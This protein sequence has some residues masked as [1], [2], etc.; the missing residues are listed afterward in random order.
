M[1]QR[2]LLRRR[3]PQGAKEVGILKVKGQVKA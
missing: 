2:G 1:L 3:R